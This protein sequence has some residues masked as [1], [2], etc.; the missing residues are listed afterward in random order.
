MLFFIAYQ[1][2]QIIAF[3][4]IIIII[5]ILQVKRG[6]IG[7]LKQRLGWVPRS[8]PGRH[9]IWLHAVSV[10]EVLSLQ[11]F[12][13]TLKSR[14]PAADCYVTVGTR[15]G[16]R[17]AQTQL[18]HIDHLSYMP[19]DFLASLW[20]AYARIKPAA[21]IIVESELWPNLV[22]IGHY[23]KVKLILLNARISQRSRKRQA[24]VRHFF[25][26]LY[27]YFDLILAQSEQDK[28]NFDALGI[29]TPVSVL[30]NLKAYNVVG[31]MERIEAMF[32]TARS[33]NPTLLV[34]S[35]HPGEA[36]IYLTL[37][38]T[39]RTAHNNLRLILAPRHFGW[40]E[41]LITK[42]KSTGLRFFVWTE[43]MVP[44]LTQRE[45]RT[46]KLEEIL[47]NH[48]IILVCTLGELF[49]LYQYADV[50]FLGGTFVPVGGHNLLEP[51]VWGV[52]TI[53]GPHY[54]NCTDIVDRLRKVEGIAQVSTPEELEYT[55]RMMLEHDTTRHAIGARSQTWLHDEARA[56]QQV[57]ETLVQSL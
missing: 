20:C 31:K 29:T 39:L 35:L 8:T 25:N 32:A 42:V 50:F 55:T 17:I 19:Y 48:D 49:S 51:A 34:G 12:I 7:N 45:M 5:G 23:K 16:M 2:I 28:K 40:Q 56:V 33:T 47:G 4:L 1:L 22:S 38:T 15:A 27:N 43:G 30:G 21:L 57:V 54:H 24:L 3:P 46:Q 53:I 41:E 18:T 11:E 36:D 13:I 37:F 10:G 6:I 52:P 9:T 14:N 44:A 26:Q